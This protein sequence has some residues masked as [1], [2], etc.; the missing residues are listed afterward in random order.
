MAVKM[1]FD[2]SNNIIQPTFALATRNGTILGFL[3][4]SNLHIADNFNSNFDIGFTVSKYDNNVECPLWSQVKNFKLV[5]CP[6]W[7]VWFEIY[8]EVE[9]EN[10]IVKNVSG[11]SVCEAELSQV[12]LFGIEI[13]TETDIARDDYKVTTLFNEEDPKASLLNRLMDKIPHYTITHVDSSIA[14][15]QRVFTFDDI[16]IY[17]AFQEIAEEINC[18][19]IFGSGMNEEGKIARTIS[20]YDLES[21]CLDCGKRGDF[22]DKCS[23]C[24]SENIVT[25]YGEDTNIFVSTNNLADGITFTTDTDSVKNCF[26]LEAGD[27]LMTATLVNCNPNGTGYLWHISDETKEDMSEELAEKLTAY[28]A[29]YEYYQKRSI[30]TLDSDLVSAYNALV[31]KYMPFKED[32]SVMI[33]TLIGYPAL[34]QAYYDTIDFY[35]YLHDELM[36]SIELS[37]TNA[38]EQAANLITAN[39][40]PVA[41]NSLSTCSVSSANS[42][43]LAMAKTLVYSDYQVKISDGQLEGHSWSGVF[44]VT[45]LSDEEDTYTTGRISVTLTDDNEA[46]I[47]Q[48]IEKAISNKS[49]EAHSIKEVFAL[50]L[51]EFT[52]ELR[53]YCLTSLNSFADACQSCLDILIQHGVADESHFLY[54]EI[55]LN[56]YNKLTVLQQEVQLRESEIALIAGKFDRNNEL[57]EDGIQTA[58]VK[59]NNTIQDELNFEN[60]IGEELWHEFCAYRREDTYSNDNFISDG[61]DNR[62]LFD[63]ALQFLDVAQK[64]IVKSSTLQHSISA[65]LKNLLVMKE[66]QPIV[67]Y[68]KVGNWIH[69]MVDN[70]VYRLRLISFEVNYDDLESI[71]IEFSDVQK[72]ATG[73]SDTESLMSQ[74][75]SMSTS[76]DSVK[77]QAE[78]GSETKKTLT[79]W[80][81]DGLALTKLKIVDN[82]QSQNITWD[83][84]GILCREY[85]PITDSYTDKQLKIINRGLYLTDDNWLTSKT[86]IGDFMYY[87]PETGEMVEAY[88]VI[89]DTLVGHLMLSEKVAIYDMNNSIM[90]DRHGLVITT[91]NPDGEGATASFTIR[92]KNVDEEGNATYDDVVYIDNE[93]NAH[94]KGELTAATGNFVGSV[95]S[96]DLFLMGDE[97]YFAANATTF[98]FYVINDNEEEDDIPLLYFENGNLAMTGTII[99]NN[100]FIGG[101][102]GWAIGDECLYSGRADHLAA[103]GGIYIGTDGISVASAIIMQ[104]HDTLFMVRSDSSS[105]TDDFAMKIVE[106]VEDYYVTNPDGEMV[107]TTGFVYTLYLGGGMEFESSFVMPIEH[108]GTGGTDRDSACP[109]LG[110]RRINSADELDDIY[111][112]NGDLC[113]LYS[114]GEEGATMLGVRTTSTTT[115]PG[116]LAMGTYSASGHKQDN[117]YFG[118]TKCY[119]NI[120]NLSGESVSSSWCRVGVGDTISGA[121]GYIV[122]LDVTVNNTLTGIDT[123]TIAFN[124]NLRPSGCSRCLVS[125]ITNGIKIAFCKGGS[126]GSSGSVIGTTTFTMPSSWQKATNATR[127]CTA[128]IKCSELITSGEYYVIFYSRTTNT[129]MWIGVTSVNSPHVSIGSASGLYLK[130]GGLWKPLMQASDG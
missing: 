115:S 129:L 92:K 33:G 111:G 2:T 4:V 91:N 46:Y 36:P 42:A 72:T 62:A 78:Q 108:G 97:V 90:M 49:K 43:V 31:V 112:D 83:E 6:E 59:Q 52:A 3:P 101:E 66:F 119:W 1:R 54:E 12:N 64:D 93:G 57:I 113:I 114:Q 23:Y 56:Y 95:Y 98:G 48:Q 28:D 89:A 86:G 10:S 63:N 9:E 20:V 124:V 37:A 8:V 77:R 40:S 18:I 5:Y 130:T 81:Y 61:L 34:M 82:A 45:N 120:A 87:D 15:I 88:G 84:H 74:V 39:L 26:K 103:S 44:T 58:I 121:C 118:Y 127:A 65:N 125:K 25:G 67:D 96:T 105:G 22:I 53:K 27:E 100:G 35:V 71:D 13:N 126:G 76:Y 30:L 7:D 69:V 73:V 55:Y 109:N 47:K 122:P 38:E 60:Y 29:L 41:V 70:E 107:L 24:E 94:F 123:I 102:N 21:H 11:I 79:G 68:F 16:T 80:T 104:P 17:D 50:D 32:L 110:M 85:L 99:A 14:G 117:S 51:D 19:F 116:Y 106:S 128:T 75:S